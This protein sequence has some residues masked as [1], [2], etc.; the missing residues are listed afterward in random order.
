VFHADPHPG[1]ILVDSSG[2]VGLIDFG[3]IGTITEEL[4]TELIVIV[5]ACVN[6]ELDVVV[7]ALADMDALGPE[8]E[9]RHLQRE[10]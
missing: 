8:T 6:N 7:D 1:N 5:Y 10:L 3:Q 9:R 2:S 4:M